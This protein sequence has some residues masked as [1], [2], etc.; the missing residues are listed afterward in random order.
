MGCDNVDDKPNIDCSN[1][2]NRSDGHCQKDF[3]TNKKILFED[4]EDSGIEIGPI[5]FLDHGDNLTFAGKY[6]YSRR[7]F[8]LLF[9]TLNFI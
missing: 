8:G 7:F 3:N 4:D 6:V 5:P 9:F 1:K 2:T